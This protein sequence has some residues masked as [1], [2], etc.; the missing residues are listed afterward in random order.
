MNSAI[1]S[2]CFGH[3]SEEKQ[4]NDI[5]YWSRPNA[6]RKMQQLNEFKQS[7]ADGVKK[8]RVNKSLRKEH[9]LSCA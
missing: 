3:F 8:I 4:I 6:K 2:R 1:N 5:A 9:V 7:T